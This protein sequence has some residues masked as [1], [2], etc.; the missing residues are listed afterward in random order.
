MANTYSRM[1]RIAD[2]IR[3]EL[4]EMLRTKVNDPRFHEVTITAVDVSADMVNAS[5]FITSLNES[6]LPATLAALNKAAGFFRHHLAHD[7]N[8][9]I[10]PRLKFVYDDSVSRGSRIA[11]LLEEASKKVNTDS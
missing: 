1:Q 10:T 2:Q 9:R 8:L 3:R 5:I 11:S 7:I 6:Q 4:A